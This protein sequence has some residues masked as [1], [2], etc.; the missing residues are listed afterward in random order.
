MQAFLQHQSESL[1]FV[2]VS[3]T[4]QELESPFRVSGLG[5]RVT[6]RSDAANAGVCTVPDTVAQCSFV[7]RPCSLDRSQS[8]SAHRGLGFKGLEFKGL[9]VYGFRV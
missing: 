4:A 8:S 1:S 7:L 5:F 3:K 9:G 2:H 6:P